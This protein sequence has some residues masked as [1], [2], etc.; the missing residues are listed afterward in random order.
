M[1]RNRKGRGKVFAFVSVGADRKA[2]TWR[3]AAHSNEVT[4]LPLSPS[5]SAMMPSVVTTNLPRSQCPQMLLSASLDAV[6]TAVSADAD[7]K[8]NT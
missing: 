8:A 6:N 3:L 2:N 4:E 5:H 7:R 1:Q